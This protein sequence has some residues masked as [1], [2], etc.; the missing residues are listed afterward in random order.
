MLAFA[1]EFFPLF[2]S[3]PWHSAYR[4]GFPVVNCVEMTVEA[5]VAGVQLN[6]GT[7][8]GHQGTLGDKVR[9]I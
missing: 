8:H 6:F 2:F 9:K 4:S 5:H 7:L 1:D 3:Y